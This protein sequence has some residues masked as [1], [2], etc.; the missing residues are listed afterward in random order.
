[1]FV[2][3]LTFSRLGRLADP[4]DVASQT[5]KAGFLTRRCLADPLALASILDPEEHL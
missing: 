4:V 5:R 2:L 3:S 1:L